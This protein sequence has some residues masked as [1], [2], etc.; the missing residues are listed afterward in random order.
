MIFASFNIVLQRPPKSIKEKR[1]EAGSFTNSPEGALRELCRCYQYQHCQKFSC[2]AILC[3]VSAV[4]HLRGA[5][6]PKWCLPLPLVNSRGDSALQIN[7][8][9]EANFTC[10]ALLIQSVTLQSQYRQEQSTEQL[11]S[12]TAMI[13]DKDKWIQACIIH[14]PSWQ[15]KLWKLLVIY[16]N[17]YTQHKLWPWVLPLSFW[18]KTGGGGTVKEEWR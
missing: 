3:I 9:L 13:P 16:D 17:F 15:C 5:I 1:D 18:E 14:C 12:V 6:N 7:T 4:T 2:S 10:T 8:Q 11:V